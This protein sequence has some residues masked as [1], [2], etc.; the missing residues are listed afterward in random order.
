MQK[1]N[2][3]RRL[4]VALTPSRERCESPAEEGCEDAG[5]VPFCQLRLFPPSCPPRTARKGNNW[6]LTR[7]I[8]NF[9]I[10]SSSHRDSSTDLLDGPEDVGRREAAKSPV[11]ER[12][13]F[14]RTDEGEFSTRWRI[15][16]AR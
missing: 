11:E 12:R 9:S 8:G 2:A 16:E 13:T 15:T 10:L 4:P 3:R 5:R 7:I 14:L 6:G 1:R